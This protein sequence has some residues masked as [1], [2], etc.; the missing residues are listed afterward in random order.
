MQTYTEINQN[1]EKLEI[2]L[3]SNLNPAEKIKLLSQLTQSFIYTDVLK[4]QKFL[5]E[6]KLLFAQVENQSFYLQYLLH[7][8][9][10]ENNLYNYN[11]ADAIYNKGIP[12]AEAQLETTQ[13]TEV[14]IDY[15]GTCLNLHNFDIANQ[16]IAKCHKLFERFPSPRMSARLL[17]RE[18]FYYLQHNN[19]AKAIDLLNQAEAALTAL[20][21]PLSLKDKFFLSLVFSGLGTIYDKTSENKKA[22]VVYDKVIALCEESGISTRLA[23]HY[24]NLGNCYLNAS[25]IDKAA[26][27]FKKSITCKDDIS[28]QARAASSANLGFCSYETGDFEEALQYF[29]KAENLYLDLLPPDLG[30][31]SVIMNGR[32]KIYAKIGDTDKAMNCFAKATELAKKDKNFKQLAQICKD[33]AQFHKDQN[34]YKNAYEYLI[35]YDD[36]NSKANEELNSKMLIEFEVKYEAEKKEKEAEFLRL[37]TTELQLKALRAQMNPHFMYN[38]LNSIQ[39]FIT[40]YEISSASN[41]LAKF[42]KLMR[43]SLDYSE[44]QVISIEK[45]LEFLEDY[46]FINKKLRFQDKLEYEIILDSEIEDD[47]IGV[48]TMIVQPYVE[49]AIEHGLRLKKDGKVVIEFRLEDDET[50][51]CI[52]QDNGIGRRQALD[53]QAKGAYGHKHQSR[54]TDITEKRLSLLSTKDGTSGG[55]TII[56]LFDPLTQESTGTR[57]EILIPIQDIIQR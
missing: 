17:V 50:I 38:A 56:D 5:E 57:V 28:R 42:A 41:Y 44:L 24:L 10:L 11:F 43:Q 15:L 23:W 4:A 20:P 49:N 6:Q 45:E 16:I 34:D 25:Q 3:N 29:D 32:A 47:I 36:F 52:I 8:A 51:K 27:Y 46:L 22:T 31:I 19:F 1:M 48:P 39:H 2:S 55:V 40:S 30:N 26:L 35:L 37:Q 54:G 9:I 21:Q 18:G 14:Y 53:M 13:L 12:L 7:S 33:I